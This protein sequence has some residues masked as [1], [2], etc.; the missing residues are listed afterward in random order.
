MKDRILQSD[1]NWLKAWFYH[2]LSLAYKLTDNLSESVKY[3]FEAIE[4]AE[5]AEDKQLTNREEELYRQILLAMLNSEGIDENK[6]NNVLETLKTYKDSYQI[7]LFRAVFALKRERFEELKKSFFDVL[8]EI[9]NVSSSSEIDL[10]ALTFLI[11]S[12]TSQ[13]IFSEEEKKKIE[14]LIRNSLIS[15]SYKFLYHCLFYDCSNEQKEKILEEGLNTNDSV[16]LHFIVELL[17]KHG[18]FDYISEIFKVKEDIL[19]NMAIPLKYVIHSLYYVGKFKNSLEL[20]E[21]YEKEFE[22]D[23]FLKKIKA[24]IF[25]EMGD[26]DGSIKVIESAKQYLSKDSQLFVHLLS[27]KLRKGELANQDVEELKRFLEEIEILD[28]SKETLLRLIGILEVIGLYEEAFYFLYRA[29][30]NL[31][32]TEIKFYYNWFITCNYD[33]LK[34]I[35]EP[36]EVNESC[37]V[38]VQDSPDGRVFEISPNPDY[39][40]KLPKDLK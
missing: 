20:I 39:T 19:K 24:S 9:E 29:H 16:L 10:I 7:P 33:K 38:Q 3:S 5:K 37:F 13:S 14:D 21:F 32:D 40:P 30:E 17:Y 6:F 18:D 8:R 31:D 26:I 11:S 28:I 4:Y 36:E 2:I 34:S 22:E 15:D 23:V 25:D 1:V 35:L 12:I 27:L